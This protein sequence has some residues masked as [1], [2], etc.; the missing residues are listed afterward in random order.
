MT[1]ILNFA[2]YIKE[3]LNY[4]TFYH[5]SPYRFEQFDMT[6]VGS[7][8]GLNKYG[9]GLYFSDSI[10][11]ATYY[12]KELS[13]GKHKHTGFN[14]YEVKLKQANYYISWDDPV[15]YHVFDNIIDKLID[16]DLTDNAETVKNDTSEE[17]GYDMWSIR[18]FY[19]YLEAVLG[20]KQQTTQFLYACDVYGVCA[21]DTHHG[22]TIYVAYSDTDVKIIDVN[23]I[24]ENNQS[25]SSATTGSFEEVVS[26]FAL[27]IFN[28]SNVT[29]DKEKTDNAKKYI[30]M[31]NLQFKKYGFQ[32]M[33]TKINPVMIYHF[34]EDL[35]ATDD[36]V[37]E[38]TV[39]KFKE[40]M[41]HWLA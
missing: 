24:N 34:M 11:A 29:T 15:P 3:N 8:D 12:A 32:L 6:K 7:G 16:L 4:Q 30:D 35:E 28:I 10:D 1:K 13:V 5:G 21:K 14:L 39:D 19:E 33:S 40:I 22:G 27:S 23:K 36:G 2:T 20:T 31:Y 41:Q 26:D 38:I 25:N 17:N 37:N 9:Y 18:S